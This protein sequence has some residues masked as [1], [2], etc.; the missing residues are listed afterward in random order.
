MAS[1]PSNH[2]REYLHNCPNSLFQFERS[3]V[4]SVLKNSIEHIFVFFKCLSLYT[5]NERLNPNRTGLF[6]CTSLGG[7]M[8]HNEMLHRGT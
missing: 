1:D 7:W 5:R 6:T 8:P 2:H 3:D 4:I